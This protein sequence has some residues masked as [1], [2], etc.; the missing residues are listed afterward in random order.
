VAGAGPASL[1]RGL[2]AWLSRYRYRTGAVSPVHRS[3][4]RFP[5]LVATKRGLFAA[6]P[7]GHA[8]IAAGE[9]YGVTFRG[10]GID[11]FEKLA[12]RG[13]VVRYR[14]EGERIADG[15]VVIRDLSPGC[16]QIDW[17]GGFLYVTDTY[18][19]R[20][21]R[22][23]EAYRQVAEYY[24]LGPCERGR[25]SENYAHINSVLFFRGDAYLVC[26]NETAKTGRASRVLRCDA[27]FNVLE[28]YEDCGASAH[29]IAFLP[30]GTGL[31][32]DSGGAR[33]I[34]LHGKV[35]AEVDLFTRGLS[36]NGTQIVVGG[37]ELAER[38]ARDQVRGR[39]YFFAPD[40]TPRGTLDLP[41][42]VQEVRRLDGDDY[43]LSAYWERHRADGAAGA[44]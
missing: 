36:A 31:V 4:G 2:R 26:H 1:R 37:S 43:S 44:G 30:D 33:V 5:Y 16:H 15:R 11:C 41:G 20:V 23:D 12:G 32:C 24:P 9:F 18:N 38:S 29:N 8:K 6:G 40:F 17:A 28:A 21:L 14:R 27:A 22:Y 25:T 39:L 34:D 19:N 3:P 10:D 7:E 13:R 35:R 42:M